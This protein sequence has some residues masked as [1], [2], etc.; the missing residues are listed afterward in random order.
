MPLEIIYNLKTIFKDWERRYIYHCI[1]VKN[2]KLELILFVALFLYGEKCYSNPFSF[3]DK[4]SELH[5][6]S[7]VGPGAF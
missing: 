1:Q 2:S 6:S 7:D 4:D 5:E 3:I